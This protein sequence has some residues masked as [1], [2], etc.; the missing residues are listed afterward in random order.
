MA[1]DPAAPPP[2]RIFPQSPPERPALP[3]P[4]EPTTPSVPEIIPIAPD[5]DVPDSSHGE[6]PSPA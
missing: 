2:D 5:N 4:S 1:T 3:D 6:W